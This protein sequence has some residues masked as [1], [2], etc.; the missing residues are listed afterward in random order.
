MVAV[1]ADNC[2][3]SVR[4]AQGYM[5]LARNR[6]QIEQM[7]N[8]LAHFGVEGALKSLAAPTAALSSLKT[9]ESRRA[10][11]QAVASGMDIRMAV[12]AAKKEGYTAR[13]AAAKPKP[14]EGKYRII[15]ADPPWKYHGLNQADEYGH[16]EAHYNCLDDDQ[17]IEFKPNR[18]R[19]IKDL[20]D[21]NTVLFIW[22]TAPLLKR[23]F[24]IIE[25]WGFDYKANFVWDKE[26]HVMGFYNSV[27]HEHLLIATKGSCTPDIKKLFNSVAVDQAHRAQPQ[28]ARVLRHHRNALRPRAQAGTIRA[29]WPRGMGLCRQRDR[30]PR[31][32]CDLH[33]R[34]GGSMTS[35]ANS[36]LLT[37][38]GGGMIKRL[39]PVAEAATYVSLSASTL[40]RLRVS[41]GGPRYAKLAGKVLYDVR[42]LD[43]WIEDSKRGS[44]SERAA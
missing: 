1:V 30:R 32:G 17:L 6:E 36:P 8:D 9:D 42:D 40:N 41:G 4:S 29:Q 10:A 20:A 5:R 27:R 18:K 23:C 31:R 13:I 44:T 26:K 11:V 3:I 12:R 43:Q 22:V 34:E 7:R 15:Y 38:T 28:A 2:Q 37:V 14:L 24:P 16:A 19:L 21:D 33:D 25:A 35:T 39:L